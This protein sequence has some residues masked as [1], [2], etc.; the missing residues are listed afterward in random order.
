MTLLKSYSKVDESGEGWFEDGRRRAMRRRIC[1]ISLSCIILVIVIVSAVVGT[2]V[3]KSSNNDGKDKNSNQSQ[4]AASLKAACGLTLYPD[5]CY[6]SLAPLMNSSR[7]E[8]VQPEALYKA[9]LQV[10]IGEISKAAKYFEE[11]GGLKSILSGNQSDIVAALEKCRELLDLATDHLNSS[12]L[13]DKL[14][15]S[16]AIE[17]ILT[18]L[19]AAGTYQ[20]T[21]ID[22][23]AN[24]TSRLNVLQYLKDSNE[25]TS[26]SLAI[27]KQV[28]DAAKSLKLRRKLL[29]ATD[30]MGMPH[31]LSF[32]D[33]KLLQSSKSSP[34]IYDAVVA[35]DGTGKYKT[36]GAALKAVPEKSKKRFTIYVKK[37]VY[38]ENVRVEKRKWNVMMVG[39]G[40]DKTV[41]SGSLNVVDGTPT[42][43]SATFGKYSLL[44][45]LP[46]NI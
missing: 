29:T 18:W 25:F 46:L 26:N 3:S 19:S 16:D 11:N 22:G 20:E 4:S 42:F 32:K 12:F 10:A 41:V 31:W 5:S 1:A 9:S 38:Y 39:D 23:F 30:D 7:G 34:I 2:H 14:T 35:K 17:D 36:I 13:S 45:S 40:M 21:C 8:I 37:G 44:H 43:S 28:S 6:R 24:T 15:S 27:I 33:R